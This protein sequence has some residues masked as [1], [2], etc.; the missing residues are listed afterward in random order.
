MKQLTKQKLVK[1]FFC[2]FVWIPRI[3]GSMANTSKNTRSK[4]LLFQGLTSRFYA[5]TQ[6]L[7]VCLLW[8]LLQLFLKQSRTLYK[9][10][11]QDWSIP[12]IYNLLENMHKYIP[13][14]NYL[15]LEKNCNKTNLSAP[16]FAIY[17]GHRISLLNKGERQWP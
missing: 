9:T 15:L 14:R 4:R 7:T 11:D 13:P 3:P 17:S 8:C 12:I 6:E 16:V 2:L 1:G 10:D 5:E